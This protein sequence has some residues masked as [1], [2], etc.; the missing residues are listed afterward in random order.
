MKDK[1][2]EAEMMSEMEAL[3]PRDVKQVDFDNQSLRRVTKRKP[4]TRKRQHICCIRERVKVR[5]GINREVAKY[6]A[7]HQSLSMI[8]TQALA[9]RVKNRIDLLR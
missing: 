7:D 4:K 2:R 1:L 8:A 5:E 6:V 3:R 9:T